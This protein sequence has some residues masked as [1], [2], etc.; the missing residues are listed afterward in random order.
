MQYQ[1]S[2]TSDQVRAIARLQQEHHWTHVRV[3]QKISSVIVEGPN[4]EQ[5]RITGIGIVHEEV[6]A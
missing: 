2:L 4:G 5:Y 3:Y 6:A 1:I